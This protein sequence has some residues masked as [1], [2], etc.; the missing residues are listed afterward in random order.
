M[1]LTIVSEHRLTQ[2]LVFQPQYFVL[3]DQL[4]GVEPQWLEGS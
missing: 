1:P 3:T 4:G 2:L